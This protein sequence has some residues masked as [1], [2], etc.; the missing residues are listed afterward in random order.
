[1][2]PTNFQKWDGKILLVLSEDR[3]TFKQA[4]KDSLIEIMPNPMVITVIL[5]EHLALLVELERYVDT[6][7]NFI[8]TVT[9]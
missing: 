9:K 1:M 3:C 5:G 2:T 4:C 8:Q 6:V 7:A